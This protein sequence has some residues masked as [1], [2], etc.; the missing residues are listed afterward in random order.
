[1][2]FLAA[3]FA[4]GE[5]ARSDELDRRHR[6]LNQ[7]NVDR[8]LTTQ[9]DLDRYD[10]RISNQESVDDQLSGAF[11]EG[12]QEGLADMQG[13]VKR[14]INGTVAGIAGFIPPWLWAVAVIGG[15]L[16]VANNLG[17]FNWVR[18]KLSA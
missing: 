15:L 16:W 2:S 5:Q 9:E 14:T 13:A 11:E 18:K 17:A 1:M 3:I 12:A 8:G 7:R 6:E 4:P 10:R